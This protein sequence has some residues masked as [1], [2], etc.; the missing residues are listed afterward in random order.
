MV[1]GFFY[2]NHTVNNF[3]NYRIQ[4]NGAAYKKTKNH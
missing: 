3:D 4:N 1:M 2:R